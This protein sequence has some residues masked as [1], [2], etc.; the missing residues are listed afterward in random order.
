MPFNHE[1]KYKPF[2]IYGISKKKFEDFLIKK[3]EKNQVQFTILR[4]FL[5]FDKNLFNKNKFTKFV[6]ERVQPLIGKG[7]NYRNFTIKENIVL[8]FFHC[9]NSKKSINKIYW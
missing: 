5:F 9:L 6:Y 1:G 2:G 3:A 4:S 7:D 8:A